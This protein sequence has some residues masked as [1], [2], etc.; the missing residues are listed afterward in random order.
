MLRAPIHNVKVKI[1]KVRR[2]TWGHTFT[3]A[4]NSMFLKPFKSQM[5]AVWHPPQAWEG[6]GDPE[7]MFQ[8]LVWLKSPDSLVLPMQSE[9]EP[10]ILEKGQR[11]WSR[12]VSLN[13]S[14]KRPCPSCN[15]N[16]ITDYD[17][18]VAT[19]VRSI[20]IL[21]I[22]A[23]E[24][25]QTTALCEELTFPRKPSFPPLGSNFKGSWNHGFC[26]TATEKESDCILLSY[27]QRLLFMAFCTPKMSHSCEA[28]FSFG[29]KSI[30]HQ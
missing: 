20:G 13:L 17:G 9:W 5:L 30:L 25:F 2:V 7:L 24:P 28:I 15:N 27:K 12:W 23:W 8:G 4:P 14:F 3:K 10:R 29:L 18:K 1:W 19:A 16:Y 21:K 26:T 11:C 22:T 6:K